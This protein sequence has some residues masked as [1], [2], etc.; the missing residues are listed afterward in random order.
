[1]LQELEQLEGEEAKEEAGQLPSVPK[2]PALLSSDPCRSPASNAGRTLTPI[3]YAFVHI[4][5]I[6]HYS[7]W[8][9]YDALPSF[10]AFDGDSCGDSDCISQ[11]CFHVEMKGILPQSGGP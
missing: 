7:R 10:E 9:L 11:E 5:S 2:V 1:M 8:E 3:P 6:D 4:G